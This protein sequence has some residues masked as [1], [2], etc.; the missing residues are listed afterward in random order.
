[1]NSPIETPR[2]SPEA[3]A[4][5]VARCRWLA[6]FIEA[7]PRLPERSEAPFLHAQL[8]EALNGLSSAVRR[9]RGEERREKKRSEEGAEK[10]GEGFLGLFRRSKSKQEAEP[11][12]EIEDSES[13]RTD[14]LIGNSWTIPLPDLIGFL[15]S[16]KKVGVLWVYSPEETF[17]IEIKNGSL[18]HATSDRTP[19]GLRIGEILVQQG[20]L[21]QDELEDFVAGSEGSMG[22]LGNALVEGGII[23]KENLDGALDYQVRQIFQRLMV[24]DDSLFR[25][26]EGME[27][28]LAHHV[29]LNATQVMLEA[30]RIRDEHLNQAAEAMSNAIKSAAADPSE[31]TSLLSSLEDRPK[32][33]RDESH[34][35]SANAQ[36]PSGGGGDTP[37][38]VLS[39]KGPRPD[40]ESVAKDGSDARNSRS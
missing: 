1:M 37:E 29:H 8:D 15:A 27:L 16:C 25:F 18:I 11:E 5:L 19:S 21:S 40:E 13:G 22:M 10:K 14:G 35:T 39:T 30:A 20:V 38:A 34:E 31:V 32:A 36:E 12:V 28:T 3:L 4:N 7:L 24:A 23:T 17:L 2:S 6:T 9:H 33:P 26:Q